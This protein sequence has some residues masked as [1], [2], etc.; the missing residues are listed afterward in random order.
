MSMFQDCF[1]SQLNEISDFERESHRQRFLEELHQLY[2]IQSILE[3]ALNGANFSRKILT[4]RVRVQKLEYSLKVK[5]EQMELD[6][7]LKMLTLD[8]SSMKKF[9][10][11]LKKRRISKVDPRGIWGEI[12]LLEEKMTDAICREECG[13]LAGFKSFPISENEMSILLNTMAG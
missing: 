12:V 11:A 8:L 13:L 7:H 2:E 10:N 9:R 3:E 1:P 4:Q 5:I 6:R